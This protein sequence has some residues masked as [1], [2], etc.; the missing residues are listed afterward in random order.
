MFGYWQLVSIGL[1]SVPSAELTASALAL[2]AEERRRVRRDSRRGLAATEPRT[3]RYAVAIGR[4]SER[5][6]GST[7]PRVTRAIAAGFVLIVA[8]ELAFGTDYSHVP[9]VALLV[10]SGGFFLVVGLFGPE[11]QR[12][13]I[14]AGE[15]SRPLVGAIAPA[16]PTEL[17]RST[18][19]L[20]IVLAFA[21]YALWFGTIT[22]SCGRTKTAR[23]L[24]SF[25]RCLPLR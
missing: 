23:P 4:A 19:W 1:G 18:V 24:V 8:L 12:N 15:Q 5:A 25:K 6:R 21:T 11:W 10:F 2:S 13:R 20:G 3:A 22:S 9:E 14:A 16:A 7:D 17:P